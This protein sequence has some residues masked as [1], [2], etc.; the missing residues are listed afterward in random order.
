M[1]YNELAQ[2]FNPTYRIGFYGLTEEEKNQI[3]NILGDEFYAFY[4]TTLMKNNELLNRPDIILAKKEDESLQKIK[5]FCGATSLIISSSA[6]DFEKIAF[7]SEENIEKSKQKILDDAIIGNTRKIAQLINQSD[8]GLSKILELLKQK[9]KHT[10]EHA[11]NVAKYAEEIGRELGLPAEK[12]KQL[13][14]AGYLYDSGKICLPDSVLFNKTPKLSKEKWD[15]MTRHVDIAIKLIPKEY[16]GYEFKDIR[17]MII[18]HHER[19][20]GTG[21]PDKTQNISLGGRILGVCDTYDALNSKCS[22]QDK[23]EYNETMAILYK[24]S[25]PSTP[26]LDRN[27]VDALE[28]VL[29][30]SKE[31]QTEKTNQKAQ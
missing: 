11:I 3:E 10:Y 7:N 17:E 1:K 24:L 4:E 23:H 21:Y 12:I 6:E 22:Y 5:Q 14:L 16:L 15:I 28:K 18:D 31:S 13:K 26:K 27:V 30:R 2:N 19:L 29:I 8:D 9:D 20:D 25:D